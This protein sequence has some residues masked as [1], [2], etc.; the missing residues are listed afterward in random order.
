LS[1]PRSH[2]MWLPA[3]RKCEKLKSS[4]G[5]TT[6]LLCV[7]PIELCSRAAF[8][9]RFAVVIVYAYWIIGRKSQLS[10]ENKL[11]LYKAILKP[12]WTYG[13]Q[14]WGTAST[15]NI[16]ILERFQAKPSELSP[17]HHGKFQMQCSTVIYESLP[18]STP[19]RTSAS[20]TTAG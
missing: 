20:R 11:L 7:G 10:V 17:T 6:F 16:E 19:W 3:T 9:A 18:S 4:V 2:G 8:W 15:S 13:I 5:S 1:R 14:L 12:T